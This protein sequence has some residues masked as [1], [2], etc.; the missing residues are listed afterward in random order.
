[1]KNVDV[2]EKYLNYTSQLPY[3]WILIL[4]FI[5]T[6]KNVGKFVW[7]K[8]SILRVKTMELSS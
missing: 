7:K 2:P 6:A 5:S 4:L 1:M 8:F 3:G